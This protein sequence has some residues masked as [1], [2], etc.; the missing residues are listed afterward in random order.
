MTDLQALPIMLLL[1]TFPHT[2]NKAKFVYRS[3][4]NKHKINDWPQFSSVPLVNN[5]SL[6][7][8]SPLSLK[9]VQ[10][11]QSSQVQYCSTIQNNNNRNQYYWL[12]YSKLTI[13]NSITKVVKVF[14]NILLLLYLDICLCMVFCF[15]NFYAFN[16][17]DTQDIN[18]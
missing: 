16:K 3:G 14:N 1:A 18:Y 12:N 5:G 4:R 17:R 15:I 7:K 9:I 11:R 13:A 10:Q 6:L 8:Y 2:L